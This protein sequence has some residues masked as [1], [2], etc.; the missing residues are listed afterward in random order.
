MKRNL[1]LMVMSVIT[2]ILMSGCNKIPQTEIDAANQ[3]LNEAKSSGAELYLPD[4]YNQT[5]DSLN[6]VVV[7]LESKK[8]KWFASYSDEKS[9][10]EDVRLMATQL[11]ENTE[12]RKNEIKNEIQNTLTEMKQTLEENKQLLTQAPQGKEGKAALEAIKEEMGMLEASIDEVMNL[13]A[14]EQYLEAQNK[15][16][17]SNEKV[18]A[19]NMEL[20]N[21]IAKS[22]RKG[23][24]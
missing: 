23:H 5:M 8:S 21:A 22:S 14:S 13:I 9:K 3:A 18:L 6:A 17:V 15:V 16:N 19:I 10:L 1:V 12:V 20:K 2:V 24:K 7:K 11:K 4:Y